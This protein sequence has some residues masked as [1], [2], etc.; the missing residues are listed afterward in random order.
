MPAAGPGDEAACGGGGQRRAGV[1]GWGLVRGAPAGRQCR[2]RAGGIAKVT[3]DL[4]DV[5]GR[6]PMAGIGRD[7]AREKREVQVAASRTNE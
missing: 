1:V 6:I 3:T 5:V 4:V 7:G 2:R